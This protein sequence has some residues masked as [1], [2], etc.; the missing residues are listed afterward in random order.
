[1]SRA[2]V[3]ASG[4]CATAALVSREAFAFAGTTVA[5]TTVGALSVL[6]ARANLI[7]GVDPSNI[8]RADAFRAIARKVGETQAPVVVTLA[9]A[10]QCA[11]TVARAAI[12]AGALHN[13]NEGCQSK[14]ESQHFFD[15]VNGY[16]LG[17]RTIA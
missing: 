5:D 9:N 10:L 14:D 13:G 8:K 3:G 6:V 12:I 2:I 4:S 7:R 16:R 17:E 15:S 11:L 1:M